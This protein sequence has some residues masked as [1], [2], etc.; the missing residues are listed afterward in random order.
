MSRERGDH[1]EGEAAERWT[2]PQFDSLTIMPR[3]SS[4]P[5]PAACGK[6]HWPVI[7][8]EVPYAQMGLITRNQDC[9]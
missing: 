7:C 6:T 9:D 1:W 2:E 8:P 5:L 3:Q 4:A